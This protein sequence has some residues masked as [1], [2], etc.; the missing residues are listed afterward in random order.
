M[1]TVAIYYHSLYSSLVS[2]HIIHTHHEP[3]VGSISLQ[4]ASVRLLAIVD[5]L[6]LIVEIGEIVV[7]LSMFISQLHKHIYCDGILTLL[8]EKVQIRVITAKVTVQT[9]A[10]FT[11]FLYRTLWMFTGIVFEGGTGCPVL[12]LG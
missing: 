6:T 7:I 5:C 11:K 4:N 8:N 3:Q 10:W 2:L 9:R 12:S 1:I